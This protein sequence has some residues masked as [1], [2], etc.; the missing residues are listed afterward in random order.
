VLY[1]L[2]QF[3]HLFVVFFT[4]CGLDAAADVD[5]VDPQ[6]DCFCSV[7]G[8]YAA[9]QEDSLADVPDDV[10][11]EGQPGAAVFFGVESV[12][13]NG[14]GEVVFRFLNVALVFTQ[15]S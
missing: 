4:G 8:I 1:I 14:I 2:K 3:L 9:G 5:S 6:F 13:Q 12:Q 10:P 11:V 15:L 7:V